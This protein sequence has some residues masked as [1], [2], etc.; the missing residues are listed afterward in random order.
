MEI[1]ISNLE[2]NTRT[3]LGRPLL[4]VKCRDIRRLV[5]KDLECSSSE[6]FRT[7]FLEDSKE[8][9]LSVKSS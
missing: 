1:S 6:S 2:S 3:T 7:T 4:K 8:G 9:L 5:M